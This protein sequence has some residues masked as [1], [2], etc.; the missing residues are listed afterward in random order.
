MKTVR[1][2][3]F[4][5]AA[6]AGIFGLLAIQTPIQAASA[7]QP[8]PPS[9]RLVD[10]Q[11]STDPGAASYA[12][13]CAVCHGEHL[14]GNLPAFPP[15]LG[16]TR[17][18]TNE[19]IVEIIR[20]GK[21]SMPGFP[22]IPDDELKA[23]LHYLAAT[24]SSTPEPAAAAGA[25][26]D[27]GAAVYADQCAICHGDQ[28]EGNLPAFPPLL[29]VAHKLTGNQIADIV[30][31]GRGRMPGFPTIPNNDLTALL[32]FLTSAAPPAPDAAPSD[33]A[34]VAAPAL[35]KAGGALFQQNCAFCHGRDAMG[36]ESGPDLTQSSLVL[37]DTTGDRISSV[38]REGRPAKKMPAFKFSNP[39]LQSLVAF[40]RAR[41][42]AAGAQKGGRRGVSVDDLQTGNAQAGMQ[43]FN[44]AGGCSKCHSPSGNLAGIAS[45]FKGLQ[46][47][48]R[49][50]YPEDAKSRV[51]VTLPSGQRV[52]GTLA[53]L[54]EFTV[55]LRDAN[56]VYQSWPIRA[57]KY[58][59]DSPVDAHVNLF[60]HY[61]DDDIHNLMAYIQT[62]R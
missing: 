46:L 56:G 49:M 24:A 55:G 7:A 60:P 3:A 35:V 48:E 9:S 17:Q 30:H 27:P 44:G 58:T 39:E 51:S 2:A 32:H 16:I 6:A 22:S 59:V 28:R 25:A 42:T 19:Q 45:R 33:T 61:T 12:N 34:S 37:S 43:Y 40:I 23:L 21:G 8:G 13:N 57:V 11:A 47:E 15:L 1:I 62:L 14:E 10:S 53:Y 36:G 54:D 52:A 4:L 18:K 38:V 26:P 50:L 29:G 31:T 5:A 20:S 41:I